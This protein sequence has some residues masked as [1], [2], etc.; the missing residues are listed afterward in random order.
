MATMAAL[1]AKTVKA[2]SVET[3]KLNCIQKVSSANNKRLW[4]L[5]KAYREAE[6][7]LQ[8]MESI[9]AISKKEVE[10]TIRCEPCAD[11]RSEAE[12]SRR[13]RTVLRNQ[14]CE[15]TQQDL[16]LH[17]PWNISAVDA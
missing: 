1:D 15:V 14:G 9:G 11:Q 4:Q 12:C 13:W 6:H 7:D 8:L 16:P 10:E 5:N 3:V 2:K 17:R